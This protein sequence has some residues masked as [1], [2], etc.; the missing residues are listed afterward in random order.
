MA[1]S[2]FVSLAGA[3]AAIGAIV[4]ACSSSLPTP[5]TGPHPPNVT[6]YIE[7][8]FPPPAAHVEVIPPKPREG[9]V[10]MDGEWDWE[11]KSWVWESGGWI[12]PPEKAYLAP[13]VTYRQDNGKL[14]FAPGSWHT[15]DGA[16]VQKPALLV[17]AESSLEALPEVADAAAE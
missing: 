8:P 1:R 2:L 17:A 7:V 4:V 13:W 14:L 12:T 6:S 15:D 16:V 9:A 5:K 3:A 10:W 11:G